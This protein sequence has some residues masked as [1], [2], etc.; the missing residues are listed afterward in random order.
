ME[1]TSHPDVF[2]RERLIQVLDISK[3]AIQIFVAGLDEG[4]I[5]IFSHRDI[6]YK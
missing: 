6:I 1:P 2:A 3:S 5:T 4:K